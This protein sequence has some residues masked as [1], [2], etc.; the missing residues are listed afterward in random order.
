MRHD[1]PIAIAVNIPG[2]LLELTSHHS[3]LR[4]FGV[5]GYWSTKN[6]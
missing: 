2:Q 3:A 1:K 5:D 4:F 6:Y